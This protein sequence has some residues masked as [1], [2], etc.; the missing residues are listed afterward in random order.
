[1]KCSAAGSR[2][3]PLPMCRMRLLPS[4]P[5]LPPCHRAAHQRIARGPRNRPSHGRRHVRHHRPVRPDHGLRTGRHQDENPPRR[6]ARTR[7][8]GDRA[9]QH[10]P[11][12]GTSSQPP[13]PPAPHHD[14]PTPEPFTNRQGNPAVLAQARRRDS[15]DKRQ[16]ARTALTTLERDG[17]KI[18]HAAVARTAHVSTPPGSP[19]PTE[20]GN[21]SRPPA[22]AKPAHH[23]PRPP[24]E[25]PPPPR[26][27]ARNSTSHAKR[28]KSS[29]RNATAYATPCATR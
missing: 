21:T 13:H 5:L 7:T 22:T 3:C 2:P 23:R 16:R 8:P 12:Q 25:D 26:D 28:S 11:A 9:R 1:M 15:L 6:H 20:S 17:T 19:T 24:K 14:R 29:A 4:R 18:T 10:P 27:C